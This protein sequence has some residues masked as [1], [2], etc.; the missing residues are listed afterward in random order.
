MTTSAWSF[1][2][3]ARRDP[4]HPDPRRPRPHPSVPPLSVRSFACA[5]QPSYTYEGPPPVSLAE[6]METLA[7]DACAVSEED[8]TSRS[9]GA[10]DPGRPPRRTRRLSASRRWNAAS[11]RARRR[12][13]RRRRRRAGCASRGRGASTPRPVRRAESPPPDR[14]LPS[15]LPHVLSSRRLAEDALAAVAAASP[16]TRPPSPPAL[17]P[18][19]WPSAAAARAADGASGS[20]LDALPDE[21][22]GVV[23]RHMG[24]Y[25]AAATS[26]TNR[27]FHRLAA[28]DVPLGRLPASRGDPG[29]STVRGE[30]ARRREGRRAVAP[31][32]I[33]QEGTP[34]TRNTR[35]AWRCAATGRERIGGSR[36]RRRR[37]TAPRAPRRPPR[38]L[39]GGN[40]CSPSVSATTPR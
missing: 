8:A 9:D 2:S 28:T 1:R 38:P 27:R 32:A 12:S 21:V 23:L 4:R 19:F 17:R 26:C 29:A 34:R 37:F 6:K 39:R 11:P 15:D 36:P 14:N 33:R 13:A 35:S 7:V 22:A 30:R 18:S 40:A 20:R 25:E 5:A 3:F 24:D 10:R 16:P 31:V